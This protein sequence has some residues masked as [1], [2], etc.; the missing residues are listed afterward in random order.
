MWVGSIGADGYGRYF[1]TRDGVGFCV[2][3][4]RYALALATQMVVG[5]DVLALHEC[6]NPVCVKVNSPTAACQHVVAGTQQENMRRMARARRGG[7]RPTIRGAGPKARRA[8]SVA[9]REAV[10]NGWDAQAVQRAL[11]GTDPTLW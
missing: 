2:R 10:R 7:G 8:R 3:P 4:N 1:I 5:S 6:D 11:L 9:L